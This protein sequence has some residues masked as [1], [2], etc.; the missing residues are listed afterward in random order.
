MATSR[1]P[2]G[3]LMIAAL[4]SLLLSG[5]QTDASDLDQYVKQV[6]S[7]HTGSVEPLPQMKPYL[8]FAYEP[9]ARRDPFVPDPDITG[10][11]TASPIPP[12]E[13]HRRLE[14]LE[15]FPLDS[16]R[17]VGTL[18]VQ[19]TLWALIRD[20]QGM[21]HRVTLGN[22]LGKNYGEILAIHDTDVRI[23]ERVPGANGWVAQETS[24]TLSE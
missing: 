12:S 5:C 4:A 21:V 8:R 2:L 17:M 16:L 6:K 13:A 9:G 15:E 14:P 20:G 11:A 3:N 23:R 1:I 24:I 7:H 22:H 19:G 10:T 18:K